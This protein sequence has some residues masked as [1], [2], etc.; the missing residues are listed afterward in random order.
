MSS[1]Y[2]NID[3]LTQAYGNVRASGREGYTKKLS[4]FGARNQ[5]IIDFDFSTLSVF[6][7]GDPQSSTMD[8][9]SELMAYIPEGAGIIAAS[10]LPIDDFDEN[11]IVGTYEKDGTVVDADGLLEATTPT[12]AGGVEVGGG[13]QIGDVTG[14]DL[15]LVIA[16][17][18]GGAPNTEG[19]GRLVVEYV[20]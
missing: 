3:G 18:I 9:F 12:V 1:L 16:N 17:A 7:E 10:I 8:A 13:A 4:T 15:Y 14:D 2:T 6:D 5:L 11:L 19:R 20:K